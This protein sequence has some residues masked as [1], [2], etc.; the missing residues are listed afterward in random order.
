M[1]IN[2]DMMERSRKRKCKEGTAGWGEKSR[3]DVTR[4]GEGKTLQEEY[5]YKA[6]AEGELKQKIQSQIQLVY[7]HET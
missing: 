4:A 7:F 6:G 5:E 3:N 1:G 2:I